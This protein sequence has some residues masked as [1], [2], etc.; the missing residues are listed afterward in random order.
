MIITVG[1]L[2]VT[3]WVDTKQ[4]IIS[5]YRFRFSVFVIS[6]ENIYHKM[7]SNSIKPVYMCVVWWILK[8]FGN[9]YTQNN[10]QFIWN[11]K[12][13]GSF[14]RRTI[15]LRMATLN[16]PI[17]FCLLALNPIRN[18]YML[19]CLPRIKSWFKCKYQRHLYRNLLNKKMEHP[20]LWTELW[21]ESMSIFFFLQ[22]ENT[23]KAYDLSI[24]SYIYIVCLINIHKHT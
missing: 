6:H 2:C 16:K 23:E 19:L 7:I 21:M 4:I 10:N 8:L 11:L 1:S 5:G 24:Y 13:I 12:M 9:Q 20:A 14:L 3:N 22:K 18:I 15:L 17:L